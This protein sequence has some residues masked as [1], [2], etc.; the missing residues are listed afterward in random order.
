MTEHT[1][2]YTPPGEIDGEPGEVALAASAQL[3]RVLL[4]VGDLIEQTNKQV[5][6][7]GRQ[8]ALEAGASVASLDE[9]WR[10]HRPR[11]AALSY[12]LG[13]LGELLPARGRALNYAVGRGE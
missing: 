8:Q 7:A 10:E 1:I 9:W 5:E 11:Q 13:Q 3:A 2:T 12:G 4:A 6:N